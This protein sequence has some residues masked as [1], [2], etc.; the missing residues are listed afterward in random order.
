MRGATPARAAARR[1]GTA[2]R[3]VYDLGFSTARVFPAPAKGFGR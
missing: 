2:A 1:L 3:V